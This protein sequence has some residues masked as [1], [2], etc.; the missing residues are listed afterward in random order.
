[1]SYSPASC[2]KCLSSPS[3]ALIGFDQGLRASRPQKGS[4]GLAGAV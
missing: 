3:K 2:C 4:H 1:M